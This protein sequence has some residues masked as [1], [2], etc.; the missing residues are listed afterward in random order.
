MEHDA[1]KKEMEEFIRLVEAVK[2]VDTTAVRRAAYSDRKAE[3]DPDRGLLQATQQEVTGRRLLEHATRTEN[4]FY[5]V[6]AK[7]RS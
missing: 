7:R 3:E 5:V 2:L 6:D 4:G 1:L